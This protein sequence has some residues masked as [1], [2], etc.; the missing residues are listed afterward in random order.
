MLALRL[1]ATEPPFDVSISLAP[2]CLRHYSLDPALLDAYLDE[3]SAAYWQQVPYGRRPKR[4]P[5]QNP[6]S[7]SVA[8]QTGEPHSTIATPSIPSSITAAH[9]AAMKSLKPTFPTLE[10][11]KASMPSTELAEDR[12]ADRYKEDV[13]GYV[14]QVRTTIPVILAEI[15]ALAQPGST[16]T[17]INNTNRYLEDV[18][19]KIHIAGPVAA[20]TSTA[21]DLQ[22][23]LRDKLPAPIRPWG[24]RPNPARDL[25]R[26]QLSLGHYTSPA[27]AAPHRSSRVR[28]PP[29]SVPPA[30]S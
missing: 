21:F 24:P 22:G 30:Q 12:D 7:R 23:L 16:I 19:V 27:A 26:P 20:T 11:I 25:L 2:D 15:V 14:E 17:V 10:A 8:I 13:R 29:A 9:A 3:V 18:E 4:K 6:E 1:T 5:R 28:R